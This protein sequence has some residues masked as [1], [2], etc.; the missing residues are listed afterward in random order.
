MFL[1][2][3]GEWL[4]PSG[5]PMYNPQLLATGVYRAFGHM[6]TASFAHGDPFPLYLSACV[7]NSLYKK[8]DVT[9]VTMED[10]NREESTL[11]TNIKDEPEAY[12]PVIERH[13]YACVGSKDVREKIRQAVTVSIVTR[14]QMI[15]E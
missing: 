5:S 6:S 11:V 10:L 14:R 4:F 12:A 8:V 15:M 13:G 2:A 1:P 3:V 7:F 9:C